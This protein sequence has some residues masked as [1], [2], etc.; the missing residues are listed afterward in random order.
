MGINNVVIAAAN[1]DEARILVSNYKED[2]STPATEITVSG[3]KNPEVV[4]TDAGHD[5][6]EIP[7]KLD[8]NGNLKLTL[9]R[10]A[11]ALIRSK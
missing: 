3:L 2:D 6:E 4:L 1:G 10:N 5:G 7:V 11:F 8:K 9:E